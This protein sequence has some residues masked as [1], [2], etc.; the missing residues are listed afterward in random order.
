MKIPGMLLLVLLSEMFAVLQPT[1][2]FA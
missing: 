1:I 2:C